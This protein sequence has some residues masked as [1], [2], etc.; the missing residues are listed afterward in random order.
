[1]NT[2][3]EATAPIA[4]SERDPYRGAVIVIGTATALTAVTA[5]VAGRAWGNGVLLDLAATMAIATA[6]LAEVAVMQ[7]ARD[8]P[9]SWSDVAAALGTPSTEAAPQ[10]SEAEHEGHPT[11][12]ARV[13]AFMRRLQPWLARI[14]RSDRGGVRAA[15]VGFLSIFAVT[16]FGGELYFPPGQMALIAAGACLLAA[17]MAAVATHYLMHIESPRFP[18]APLLARAA[19]VSAWVLVLAAASVAL[20]WAGRAGPIRVIHAALVM[21][22]VVVCFQL[23]MARPVVGDLEE[24]FPFDLGVLSVLGS[25]PNILASVLDAMEGQLGIDLRSTWALTV[26]RRSI[27]PLVIALATL[28]WLST[29]L[30]VVGPDED[31]IVERL[32]VP[33]QSDALPPGLHLHWPWPIDRVF[34]IP[35]RHVQML[36]VG[37]EGEEEGGPEDVLWARQHAANE[38][39]LLLGN[40]RDLITIDAQVQY[41]ITD[42]KAWRYHTQNPSQA[43]SAIAYRAVMRNT[44]NKTLADALS[45]NVVSLTQRMHAQVQQEADTLGLGVQVL[46]FTVGGMHPPVDVAADYQ[47]VVSAAVRKMTAMAD[48]QSYRNGV[49]PRADATAVAAGNRARADGADTLGRATGEASSFLALQAQYGAN[50]QEFF[51]RRRLEQFEKDLIGR[52]FTIVDSRIQRDGGELWVNP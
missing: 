6:V 52:N 37:H 3:S 20:A 42:P 24:G 38:Y 13:S 1:M 28:A 8:R 41:R 49:I 47:A 25:R 5:V 50:P 45:E 44:V 32:G 15:I 46:S 43:L 9:S 2:V 40:G 31:A 39:T 18:E 29:S 35:V 4:A 34:R 48:A 11:I 23:A 10:A 36:T 30:T 14:R 26:V 17:A 16:R 7:A 27:E 12:A 51:F 21:L 19:R 33:V 22:N